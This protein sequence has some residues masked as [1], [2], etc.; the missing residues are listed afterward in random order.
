MKNTTVW[1]LEMKDEPGV[2]ASVLLETREQAR[3]VNEMFFAAC[4]VVSF[5]SMEDFVEQ[6]YHLD[7]K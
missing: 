1:G 6:T 3:F 2:F 4:K 5:P 7:K